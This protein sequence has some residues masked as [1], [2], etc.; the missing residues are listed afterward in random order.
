M[1]NPFGTVILVIFLLL[2]FPVFAEGPI[3]FL[4][5]QNGVQTTQFESGD[6]VYVEGICLPTGNEIAKIYVTDDKTWQTNDRISDVS[7]GIETFTVNSDAKIPRT[8]IWGNPLNQGTYDVVIDTNSD[9]ILQAHEQQCIIGLTDTGFRVGNPAP[10]PPPPTPPPPPAPTP[11]PSPSPIPAKPSASFSL[12]E[13]IEVSGLSNVR[14]SPGGTLIGSQEK[15]T[16][17]VVV[18]GPAQASLSGNYYWFWNINFENDP[19]GWVAESMLKSAPAPAP[20]EETVIEE[21][22]AEPSLDT[23]TAVAE[24]TSQ[25]GTLTDEEMLAQVSATDKGSGLNSFMGSIII[26]AALF[27]GLILGSIIIARVLRKN[28]RLQP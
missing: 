6:D 17:G 12:G 7:A 9:F 3:L 16:L 28:Q 4:T 23:E 27:L 11:P 24:E 18:G 13:Y 20:V 1:K 21:N 14:K 26:G 10:T 2:A 25:E 8:K 15:G 5:N 19:D 22:V